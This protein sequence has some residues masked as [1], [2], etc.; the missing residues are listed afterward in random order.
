MLSEI[1][2]VRDIFMW[3]NILE[4]ELVGDRKYEVFFPKIPLKF[5]IPLSHFYPFYA[6]FFSEKSMLVDK[7]ILNKINIK[8]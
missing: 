1:I 3:D 4:K 7:K 5:H 8:I 6:K 2:T